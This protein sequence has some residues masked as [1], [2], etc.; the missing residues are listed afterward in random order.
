MKSV[1]IGQPRVHNWL[2]FVNRP[3]AGGCHLLNNI[4]D[5]FFGTKISVITAY[6]PISFYKDTVHSVYHDLCDIRLLQQILQHIHPAQ[7]LEQ[8]LFQPA[9][10]IQR[11]M[12]FF[13]ASEHHLVNQILHLLIRHFP[14]QINSFQD[15]SFQSSKDFRFSL[16]IFHGSS[17][18]LSSPR[19]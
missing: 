16:L 15:L 10:L 7:R 17:Y 1:P 19:I 6:L 12:L 2:R 9:P 4:Q 13:S 11:Q 14:A 8:V 5:P 18:S 3:V